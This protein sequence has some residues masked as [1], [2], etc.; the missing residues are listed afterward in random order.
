MTFAACFSLWS[1]TSPSHGIQQTDVSSKARISDF[2]I[3]CK[4]AES[5]LNIFDFQE[6]QVYSVTSVSL[7]C[8]DLLADRFSENV[9][10]QPIRILTHISILETDLS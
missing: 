9:T 3:R 8:Q 2:L 5:F 7:V 6:L 4:S 1:L 10:N